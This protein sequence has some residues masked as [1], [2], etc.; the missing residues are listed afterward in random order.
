M[1]RLNR[2]TLETTLKPFAL[3][4]PDVDVAEEMLR[5]WD[6]LV[7]EGS[8]ISILVWTGDGSE[9]LEWSGNIDAEFE[10]AR[11]IGFSNPEQFGLTADAPTSA[12]PYAGA[13][14][15][16]RYRRLREIVGA[17][18]A[19]ALRRKAHVAIGT[20]FDPGPEFAP[21][22]FKFVR[23]PEI[24]ES[25]FDLGDAPVKTHYRVTCSWSRLNADDVAYAAF[26]EGIPQG[27]SFGSFLGG[28]CESFLPAMGFDYLWLSNGF[29]LSFHPWS[30]RGINFDG[31]RFGRV[32]VGEA[33]AYALSFWDDFAAACSYSLEVR[34]TNFPIG[35]E[36]AKD[37]TPLRTI[38]ERGYL[39]LP[40]PNSPW[41]ALNRNFG[42]EIAGAMSRAAHIPGEG[43]PF[44]FYA[45]DP[46]FWQNPW[47]D[48][49]G[50]EPYDIYMPMS[51]AALQGDG[52]MRTA[53][54]VEILS[55]D[56]EHGILDGR[57][58]REIVP[59]LLSGIDT[60]PDRPGLLCWVYPFEEMSDLIAERPE[61]GSNL[62]LQDWF[63]AQAFTN[64]VPVNS[65]VST[66]ELS[67][68]LA[69]RQDVLSGT[70]LLVCA[71]TIG[72]KVAG[73]LA[74]F[75][76]S[77]GRV[78]FYGAPA[79][80]SIRA[81]LDLRAA[82][83]I[84]GDATIVTRRPID[85][86][87][88][89]GRWGRVRMSE[90][91]SAGGSA[92][93]AGPAADIVAGLEFAG[94]ERV[95]AVTR[96]NPG[97]NGGRASWIRAALPIDEDGTADLP[98]RLGE[99]FVDAAALLRPLLEDFGSVIRQTRTPEAAVFHDRTIYRENARAIQ[100]TASRSDNALWL[101]G[102]EQDT[103]AELALCLPGGIPVPVGQTVRISDG[104][105]V[106]HL[107]SSFRREVRV[108]VQ[109][110]ADG[111]VA[112]KDGHPITTRLNPDV[113]RALSVSPVV[114]A[115]IEVHP[116]WDV[117]ERGAVE[118]RVD[119]EPLDGS[120]VARTRDGVLVEHVSGS[121]E[122]IW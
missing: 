11:F 50:R 5:Q 10:W 40:A 35:V 81:L 18:R 9:I 59:H 68:I 111:P 104:L 77:G 118:V 86:L 58:A 101:S 27:L 12:R 33:T 44:R 41:G 122:F 110:D 71:A 30:Y 97:W 85:N 108:Y 3:G 64:G 28:Q 66:A 83:A 29:G 23:H 57:A 31:H 113:R 103:T 74:N 47:R 102:Y 17:L 106:L 72:E 38:Y 100:F 13:E 121:I 20:A 91:C 117:L 84:E 25:P 21:S 76:R 119:G 8:S 36:L 34:G 48:C 73:E 115:R 2:V 90:A 52:T 94:G 16:M 42:V 4:R 24:S 49:Y 39:R 32:D 112:C 56:S 1:T 62:F 53:S 22:D 80:D 95:F 19:A 65:V 96:T 26:P 51:V 45:N 93:V 60:A 67:R 63:V 120:L 114:D 61:A 98:Q 7:A 105:G 78:L 15:P 43:Y 99:E 69:G 37:L 116:P 70:I 89:I 55:V 87:V 75:V 46:W 82:P 14:G 88:D 107:D 92:E 79:F 109:Q 54:V 6:D